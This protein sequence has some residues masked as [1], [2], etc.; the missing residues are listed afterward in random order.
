[1][2]EDG[3]AMRFEDGSHGSWMVM[4]CLDARRPP[5]LPGWAQPAPGALRLA[6]RSRGLI[7]SRGPPAPSPTPLESPPPVEPSRSNHGEIA[8]NKRRSI[9]LH[10]GRE[11]ED[12][13]GVCGCS[14]GEAVALI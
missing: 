1:M 2:K 3:E 6:P 14:G 5:R 10:T 4:G 8:G 7:S 9:W 12:Q 11:E 13:R